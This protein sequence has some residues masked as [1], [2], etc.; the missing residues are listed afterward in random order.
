MAYDYDLV[1]IGSGPAGE[2]GATQAGYFGKK[3]A[4][5]RE[6]ARARRRD[7]EHRHPLLEDPPR[8]VALPLRLPRPRA[9]RRRPRAQAGHHRAG[10]APP[11]AAG[12]A[13]RARAGA[14]EPRART[15]STS[16]TGA[17]TL[18][19]P[20]TVEI[21]AAGGNTRRVTSEVIL[22]ATGSLSRTGPRC[23]R[24]R[25]RG[26]TTRTAPPSSSRSRHSMAVVGGGVIGCEYACIFAALGVKVTL[27]D[28]RDRAAHLP[29]R[30]DVDSRSRP[31]WRDWGSTSSA[32]H[33]AEVRSPAATAASRSSSPR[34][35]SIAA[36]TR[37]SSRSAA[38]ATPAGSGLEEARRRDRQARADLGRRALP[39]ERS[40]TSTRRAT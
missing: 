32:G 12:E 13:A 14:L 30:R 10:P 26:S 2:K 38:T 35:S 40:R 15:G 25:T 4:V 7:R 17:A 5:D 31:R 16:S 8:D 23:T 19:D 21:V 36:R 3:V 27:I 29:R 24:S 37:C 28:P 22:I 1:V 18:V 6:G 39:D 20:H 9:L 33:G 11:R 34:A